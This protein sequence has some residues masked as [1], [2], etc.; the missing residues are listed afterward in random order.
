[1]RKRRNCAK[2]FNSRLRLE[3]MARGLALSNRI[4]ET[5][6]E[7]RANPLGEEVP[8]FPLSEIQERLLQPAASFS[9][10]EHRERPRA[11]VRPR[12]DEQNAVLRVRQPA[13]AVRRPCVRALSGADL[14][15]WI[16]Q[17]DA[18]L[19][20]MGVGGAD[21]GEVAVPYGER[22]AHSVAVS[23]DV[24]TLDWD[25]LGRCARFD[26]VLMDPRGRSRARTRRAASSSPTSSWRQTRSRN[27]A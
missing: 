9:A 7:C 20:A 1:L 8:F 26:V 13:R 4:L 12:C 11:G 19:D 16:E 23:V 27:T 18:E 24:R 22:T 25:R 3:L 5:G 17:I 14:D 6:P 10:R 2:R 21:G 15:R